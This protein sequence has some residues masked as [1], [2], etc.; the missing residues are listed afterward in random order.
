M[1]SVLTVLTVSPNECLIESDT[2]TD[3]DCAR[4]PWIV[5]SIAGLS[6]KGIHSGIDIFRNLKAVIIGSVN[7]LD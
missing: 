1:L 5:S 4:I 6:L 3:T 2:Q 7:G